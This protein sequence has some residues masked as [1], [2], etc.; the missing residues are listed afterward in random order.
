MYSTSLVG[1]YTDTKRTLSQQ[2]QFPSDKTAIFIESI[3]QRKLLQ[4]YLNGFFIRLS[5][6]SFLTS[7]SNNL[8]ISAFL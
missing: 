2:Y 5:R 4:V 1:H 6:L 7:N 3:K 8:F